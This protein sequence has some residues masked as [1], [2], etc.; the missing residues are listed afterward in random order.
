MRFLVESNP[1]TLTEL[2]MADERDGLKRILRRWSEGSASEDDPGSPGRFR[3]WNDVV[4]RLASANVGFA[5]CRRQWT[6][7]YPGVCRVGSIQR[8][9]LGSHADQR[10]LSLR[11]RSH[12]RLG[13]QGTCRLE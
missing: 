1:I 3:S 13:G 2:T 6:N 11:S 8:R 9:N 5:E 7:P 10:G 12:E 4:S